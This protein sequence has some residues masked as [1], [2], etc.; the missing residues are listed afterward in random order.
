MIG[1]KKALLAILPFLCI[2]GLLYAG[3]GQGST[4]GSGGQDIK[5][6]DSYTEDALWFDFSETLEI[7]FIAPVEAEITSGYGLRTHP[8]TGENS[9]HTG[10]DFG[11][12]EGT[13]VAA[14]A[15]GVVEDAGYHEK[16]GYYILMKHS[17]NYHSYYAHCSELLVEP[18]TVIRQGEIIALS[19]N[20]GTYT[21]GPHLHFEIRYQGTAVNA[22]QY[23]GTVQDA[24]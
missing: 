5:L 6:S 3:T 14:T 22:M 9:L 17:D 19:G 1:L 7:S 13:R 20:T 18:G 4:T 21:T 16:Y 15:G 2:A 12:D 11:V 23:I 24:L 8:I 10:T